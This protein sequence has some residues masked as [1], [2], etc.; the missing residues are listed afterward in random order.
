MNIYENF[1][2][3]MNLHTQA[4]ISFPPPTGLSINNISGG[5]SIQILYFT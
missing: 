1:S 4:T 2:L 3:T 5:S